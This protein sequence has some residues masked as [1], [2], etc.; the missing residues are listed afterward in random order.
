MNKYEYVDKEGWCGIEKD[1]RSVGHAKVVD[2][3]KDLQS[4]LD[5]ADAHIVNLRN[6][7]VGPSAYLN[8]NRLSTIGT[9]SIYHQ[10]MNEVLEV[11]PEQSLASI[12]ADAIRGLISA[13]S[14]SANVDGCA[15]SVI[16]VDDAK[17]YVNELESKGQ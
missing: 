6:A 12:K 7:I 15:T 13:K 4:K 3:I 1:G 11:T 2:D 16:Y 5:A 17:E 9:D 14:A 10:I 8:A